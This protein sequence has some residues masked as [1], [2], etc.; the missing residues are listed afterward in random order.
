MRTRLAALN[1]ARPALERSIAARLL[2]FYRRHRRLPAGAATTLLGE[3]RRAWIVVQGD[4]EHA[5][6][7]AGA[8]LRLRTVRRR[9]A[10]RRR[11]AARRLRFLFGAD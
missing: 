3:S 9:L 7:I 8:M 1:A 4:I 6:G 10:A 11:R 2:D 5:L